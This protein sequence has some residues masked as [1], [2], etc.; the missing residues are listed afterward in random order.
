MSFI[1]TSPSVRRCLFL[2]SSTL[3]P[4]PNA[5]LYGG[6]VNNKSASLPFIRA[7]TADASVLSPH[8]RRCLPNCQISPG[9]VIGSLLSSTSGTSSSVISAGSE[10]S[11]ISS[12][13]KSKSPKSRS[14]NSAS[15]RSKFH[16]A[17]SAVL[18]SS[19]RYFFFCSSVIPDLRTHSTSLYPSCFNAFK[20]VCPHNITLSS[21]IIIGEQ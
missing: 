1:I 10:S 6:S 11:G 13:P 21:S 14:F 19:M 2:A 5:T 4:I 18:L 7:A 12:K 15:K 17:T 16:S 8:I 9:F 3:P 20:R